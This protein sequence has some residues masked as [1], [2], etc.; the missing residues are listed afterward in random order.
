M[1]KFINVGG[2]LTRTDLI[3]SVQSSE[4]SYPKYVAPNKA[5]QEIEQLER[6]ISSREVKIKKTEAKIDK[7][8]GQKKTFFADPQ[9]EIS[10]MKSEILAMKAENDRDCKRVDVL[11]NS[12]AP[13]PVYTGKDSSSLTDTPR[14]SRNF[15]IGRCNLLQ[16]TYQSGNENSTLAVTNDSEF[17][18]QLKNAAAA[19]EAYEERYRQLKGDGGGFVKW[20]SDSYE[21]KAI[22]FYL[23]LPN[24]HYTF[25]EEPIDNLLSSL[26]DV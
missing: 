9:K 18:L 10:K 21:D 6:E 26:A 17:I 13:K 8:R 12:P 15:T 25:V 14:M 11:R 24:W 4:I 19:Y 20:V 2:N 3:E 23:N 22:S 5:A 7:K 1:E 16:I